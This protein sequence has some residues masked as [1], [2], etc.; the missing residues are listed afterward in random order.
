MI[1]KAIVVTAILAS[2]AAGVALPARASAATP[3]PPFPLARGAF[4]VYRGPTSWTPAGSDQVIERVLTW[5]ME[6]TDV[7]SR[8][9]VQAA[10]VTGHPLDLAWYEEDRRP[11]DYLIV[12]VD[13]QK[14]Y[15]LQGDRVA[16]A[17]KR[18]RDPDDGQ[19]GLVA[20]SDL[21][22]D[23]PL[24]VDKRFGETD[25]ITRDDYFYV[26]HVEDELQVSLAGITGIGAPA[27]R[28]GYRLALRTL[29]EHEIV[30]FVPGI[31]IVHVTY[32]H[33]GT[34]SEI[35][36]QLIEFHAGES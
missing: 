12:S 19:V 34:V 26:W 10:V 33:H 27:E 35:D 15:L 31:G 28:T 24:T 2:L 3:D 7:I 9:G 30:D 8:A 23:L 16:V 11:R 17:T 18:L 1:G 36:Q 13:D 6:I 20:D 21:F 22:L 4:W 29:P 32:G 5:R 25:Q 14:Y